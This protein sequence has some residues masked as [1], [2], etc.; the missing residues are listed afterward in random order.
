[1]FVGGVTGIKED[2]LRD[3]FCRFGY[4]QSCILNNEKRHAFIKM[5][6]R[7]DA[8]AAKEGMASYKWGDITIR[9]GL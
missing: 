9:V 3:L 7:E 2:D 4:V 8:I 5:Y 6:T 1:L